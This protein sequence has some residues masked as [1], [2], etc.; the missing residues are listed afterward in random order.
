MNLSGRRATRGAVSSWMIKGT[1]CAEAKSKAAAALLSGPAA[2]VT[3]PGLV[4]MLVEKGT[5]RTQGYAGFSLSFVEMGLLF[6]RERSA[7]INS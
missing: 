1:G 5:K 2:P 6:R 4:A 7:S 3:I